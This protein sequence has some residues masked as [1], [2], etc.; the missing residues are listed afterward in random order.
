MTTGRGIS[1]IAT[2]DRLMAH[3]SQ[4]L[5]Y[6][7][8]ALLLVVAVLITVDVSLRFIFNKPIIG[9][10]EIVANGIVII[11]FLQLSYAIRIG[12]MLRSELLL[13]ALGPKGRA[14]LEALTGLLGI[15]LFALIAWASWDPMMR[16]ISAHEFEGHA[17]FQVPTWPLKTTIVVCSILGALDYL[18]VAVKAVVLGETPQ[19]GAPEAA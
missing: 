14:A 17:S 8:A 13:N 12:G 10:A 1:V 9:I 6:V 11:A 15:L 3:V 7:A 18:M 2:I 16:A 19:A 5:K 4:T